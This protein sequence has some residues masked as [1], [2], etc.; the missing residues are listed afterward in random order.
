M[1]FLLTEQ[2][3]YGGSRGLHYVAPQPPLDPAESVNLRLK[4]VEQALRDLQADLPPSLARTLFHMQSHL[5]GLIDDFLYESQ[6]RRPAAPADDRFPELLAALRAEVK[7]REA[8][9]ARLF[10]RYDLIDPA[11]QLGQNTTLDGIASDLTDTSLTTD[12]N[13]LN[14]EF[15]RLCLLRHSYPAP[16][17]VM[18][19]SLASEIDSQEE[20][21]RDVTFQVEFLP[22]QLM[23]AQQFVQ[24]F[25]AFQQK[26]AEVRPEAPPEPKPPDLSDAF[27]CL[28]LSV[29]QLYESLDA[30]LERLSARDRIVNL[31]CDR[32]ETIIKMTVERLNVFGDALGKMEDRSFDAM[33]ALDQ[34]QAALAGMTIVDELEGVKKGMQKELTDLKRDAKALRAEFIRMLGLPI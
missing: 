33:I 3:I 1:T 27:G 23:K 25:A 22:E 20:Q 8:E 9:L 15:E 28:E 17:P 18:V 14:A 34:R 2:Q 16:V 24:T 21:I 19:G 26:K 7:D 32:S 11:V 5:N 13:G 12:T 29:N 30:E 10:P 4:S 6:G 31:E